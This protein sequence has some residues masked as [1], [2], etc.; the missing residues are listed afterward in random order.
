MNCNKLALTFLCSFLI[1]TATAQRPITAII[2]AYSNEVKLLED[3]LQNKKIVVIK[4]IR[5]MTGKLRKKQ[6]VVALT[7]VGKVNA[8]MTTSLILSRWQPKRLI[9]TGIAGGLNPSLQPGDLVIASSTVQHDYG[10]VDAT[11]FVPQA[12]HNALDYRNINPQFFKADSLMMAIAQ[13]VNNSVAFQ[14]VGKNER[15]PQVMTGIIATGDVFINSAERSAWLI[16]TFGADAAEMEGAAVV[17][18][19]YHFHTPCLVIR[20]ISDNANADAHKD[21]QNFEGVAAY[22]SANLVL[23]I[24]EEL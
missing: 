13:S 10:M 1:L 5:F 14:S 6:V 3:S 16:K 15:K 24:L 7:G 4:G 22:N 12:T 19:C 18:V 21:I 23:R 20:S 17:Q 9:F 11:G 2:G 8:A